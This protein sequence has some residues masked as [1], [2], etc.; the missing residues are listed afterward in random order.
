MDTNSSSAIQGAEISVFLSYARKDDDIIHF[1]KPFKDLLT[2]FVGA[3]TGREI[4]TFVD[5]HNIQWGD[6]W[7]EEI[8]KSLLS[9]TVFIPILSAN[10]LKS[11]NCR[12]EFNTFYSAASEMGVTELIL[13]VFLN[14]APTLFSE[15]SNDEIVQVVLNHQ[16]EL[17]EQASLSAADSPEWKQT[18]SQLAARFN[19]SYEKAECKLA[20][21]P[22][23]SGGNQNQN[24]EKDEDEVEDLGYIEL[25]NDFQE[26]VEDVTICA[27]ELQ[28]A[29]ETIT[30]VAKESTLTQGKFT[31]PKQL[32]AW[33]ITTA[34]KFK[35][36]ALDIENAGMRLFTAVQVLDK[37][38]GGIK[39][40][41]EDSEQSQE[42][43]RKMFET[44]GDLSVTKDQL[45]GLLHSLNAAEKMSAAIRRSLK[46]MR[47][48]ITSV[49]DSLSI[50]EGWKAE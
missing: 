5:R 15:G 50:M 33:A 47:A 1:I 9:A 18:M 31:R 28:P 29:L 41:S 8:E 42:S 45:S 48:G 19:A 16:Y 40:M 24:G 38:V 32:Q 27:S 43:Y 49:Q 12:K 39:K 46:P 25:L 35:Q 4:S 13:P 17:I 10:Y 26:Q 23:Q 6:F 21:L 44:L 36:P 22:S 3:N 11:E 34:N 14:R 2:H 37:T 7:R 20:A 30:E